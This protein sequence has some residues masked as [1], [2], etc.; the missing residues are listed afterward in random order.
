MK[1]KLLA[2]GATAAFIA[3][4][5]LAYAFPTP[6]VPTPQPVEPHGP[7]GGFSGGPGSIFAPRI[8]HAPAVEPSAP[9]QAPAPVEPPVQAP[10]PVQTPVQVQAPASVP[11]TAP[12]QQ[13][14]EQLP[15]SVEQ[16][17]LAPTAEQP[18]PPKPE[19][20]VTPEPQSP[21]TLIQAP[22]QQPKADPQPPQNVST[23]APNDGVSPRHADVLS[24]SASEHPQNSPEAP[25][26]VDGPSVLPGPA[27]KPQPA[28]PQEPAASQTSAPKPLTVPKPQPLT[29]EQDAVDAAQAVPP[30][31][32]DPVAPPPPPPG[33]IVDPVR[34][35]EQISARA[36]Q[37]DRDD[38]GVMRPHRWTYVDHDVDGHPRFYNPML[39][40]MTLRYFYG[41]AYRDVFVA[42]GANIV[43][44]II[45]AGVFPFTAV[46]G[47]YVTTGAFTAGG[48][49]P[50]TYENVAADVVNAGRTVQVGSVQ[51][52]GHDETRP[53]GEQDAMMVDGST[54][55]YGT[56]RDPAHVE[57]NKVQ[58][59][60]G[61]GPVDDGTHWVNTASVSPMPKSHF[62][63]W[64]LGGSLAALLASA[65]A[66]AGVFM[67]RRRNP[68]AQPAV[69]YS[70]DPHE[71]TQWMNGPYN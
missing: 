23:P 10:A 8:Q 63:T 12:V 17:S 20:K 16:P 2:A 31:H 28:S 60:P 15:K 19:Q 33:L 34:Q 57:I 48:M 32:I 68:V 41:G 69:A 59:L 44:D 11:E 65:G 7:V 26:A 62:R 24:P 35:A 47:D 55:A 52:I 6:V 4:A 1:K 46:G 40:D 22:T 29:A 67:R 39:R 42:A 49:E 54:L 50:T 61:V 43:L 53:P 37:G 13:Q 58:T 9:V 3:S 5:P 30:R 70:Y 71:P 45:E 51:L 21:A 27:I 38:L 66:I 56:V 18:V 36:P 14:P 25:K 64:A